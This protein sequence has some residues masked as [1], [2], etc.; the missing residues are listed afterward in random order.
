MLTAAK[1]GSPAIGPHRRR[2]PLQGGGVFHLARTAHVSFCAVGA[3]LLTITLP[4]L[5]SSL[6]SLWLFRNG[7][8]GHFGQTTCS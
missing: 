8:S 2:C 6:S 7:Q 3:T 5:E 4:F 1:V